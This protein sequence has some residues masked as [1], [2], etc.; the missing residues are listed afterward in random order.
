MRLQSSPLLERAVRAGTF[1]PGATSWSQLQS[2]SFEVRYGFLQAGPIILSTRRLNRGIKAQAELVPHTSMVAV[3]ADLSTRGRWFGRELDEGT[4][5]ATDS[6]V[7]ISTP[8]AAWFC[9]ITIDE[10]SLAR[11]FPDT[12]DVLGLLEQTDKMRLSRDPSYARR[13]RFAIMQCFDLGANSGTFELPLGVPARNVYGTLVPLAAGAM[14]RFDTHTVEA[15]K[16]LT[17]RVA[18]VRSCEAYMREHAGETVTLLDLCRVSQMRSRSLIN[19]FEAIRGL[20]PMEYL[21]RV[22]LSGVR[23]TL[24]LASRETTRIIDVA[25]DWGFW[26]MGHFSKYYRA[27]FGELPSQTLLNN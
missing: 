11:E 24:Q 25:T 4:I 20:S 9:S 10:E 19:A 12:P 2:G 3:A 16:S 26:H 14:E 7:E 13:L 6:S 8:G 22:R 15:S 5:F 21:K 23:Q 1:S 17:R 18:A 27:M